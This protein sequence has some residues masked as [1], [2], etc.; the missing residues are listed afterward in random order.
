M[1]AKAGS[2]TTSRR[3][4]QRLVRPM[5]D[6]VS[7]RNRALEIAR[8][9]GTHGIAVN[10]DPHALLWQMHNREIFALIK[11]LHVLVGVPPM[12]LISNID[13]LSS[14]VSEVSVVSESQPSKGKEPSS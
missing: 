14:S 12:Q 7:A 6:A 11:G 3:S 9:K 13:S 5:L 2:V 4:L 10:N 8:P 1:T